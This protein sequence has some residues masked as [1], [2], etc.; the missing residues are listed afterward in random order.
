MYAS[1]DREAHE[2]EVCYIYIHMRSAIYYYIHT[3]GVY[4]YIYIY[5]HMRSAI[6]YYICIYMRC[7]YTYI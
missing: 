3:Y 5:I 6:Y 1:A 2:T 4:I 7:I